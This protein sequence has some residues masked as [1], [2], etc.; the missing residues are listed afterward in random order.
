VELQSTLERETIAPG[1]TGQV[2]W[3]L[4]VLGGEGSG[5][6]RPPLSVALVLDVS[7]SM[8]GAK[9][10]RVKEAAQWVVRRLGPQDQLALVT[11][12]DDVHVLYPCGPVVDA[13]L[14]C[15][16]ITALRATSC[17]NLSGGWSEGVEQV[18]DGL[19]G[20]RR[21]ILLTDGEANR[22]VH[23]PAHLGRLVRAAR[24]DH[25][26]STS[27]I[28]VGVDYDESLLMTVAAEG[29]G[30]YHYVASPEDAARAFQTELQDLEDLVA[31]NVVLELRLAPAV[32]KARQLTAHPLDY[33]R[34]QRLLR[35]RVGDVSA[36]SYRLVGL[37][38][39]TKCGEEGE[40][41]LLSGELRYYDVSPTASGPQE[42][43]L[44]AGLLATSAAEAPADR[45]QGS[46]DG[47]RDLA[48]LRLAYA[49]RKASDYADREQVSR[50][51]QILA[52]ARGVVEATDW[53]E[54]PGVQ[55]HVEVL[56]QLERTLQRRPQ[57]YARH[58]A[59]HKSTTSM[60]SA[61]SYTIR[62]SPRSA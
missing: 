28:G 12:S 52:H 7:G 5:P 53:V 43:P 41:P 34:D 49:T 13:E 18:R 19:P 32:T 31:Q 17:T 46:S 36:N 35:I 61:L 29:G 21:V 8:A 11:F 44:R 51:L 37:E 48:M 10:E 24:T 58:S 4:R 45:E 55:A 9:L 39:E 14:L 33:D 16:R 40:L 20:T 30:S 42:L 25:G 26:V 54:D 56:R 60:S 1:T 22:G 57:D 23:D 2:G 62:L 59:L 50:A 27:T 15:A 3:V 6:R 47:L 38:V